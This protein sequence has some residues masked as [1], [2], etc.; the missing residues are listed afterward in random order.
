MLMSV[1]IRPAH[2]LDMD[3]I[4]AIQ[5]QC[6]HAIEPESREAMTSK[7]GMTGQRSLVAVIG[8]QVIGYLLCHPWS[9]Y[10]IPPLD[11]IHPEPASGVACLYLHDLAISPAARG[12]GA[13]R[14]LV[15]QAID[16]ARGL[17]LALTAIQQSSRF[18]KQ[19]GFQTATCNLPQHDQLA[20]Y[21]PDACYMIRPAS[22]TLHERSNL[23]TLV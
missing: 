18:W 13:A 2:D 8:D 23:H 14:T 1:D 7:L 21:G 5:Q 17:P 19:H 6:Y 11:C 4:M 20:G 15:E 9:L 22:N 3:A 16:N 12:L 10:D